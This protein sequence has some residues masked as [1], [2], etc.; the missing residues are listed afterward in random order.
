MHLT[1]TLP[2][3]SLIPLALAVS[4]DCTRPSYSGSSTWTCR[5]Y[6]GEAGEG[7]NCGYSSYELEFEE[8]V[9]GQLY[10]DNNRGESV[11]D[12]ARQGAITQD[13]AD[14][15]PVDRCAGDSYIRLWCDVGR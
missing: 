13:C 12:M 3:L 15:A 4:R 6:G 11:S 2:L 7:Q 10:V 5:W 8:Q 1:T 9:D 14:A